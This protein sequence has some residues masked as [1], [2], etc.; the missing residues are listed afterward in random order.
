MIPFDFEYYK[1]ESVAEAV[2][3]FVE[4]DRQGKQPLYFSGG[5]EIISMARLNSVFTQAVVDIKGIFEC[6]VLEMRDNQLMIGAAVT[7]TRILESNLFPLLGKSGGRIADHTI[8]D[9][10]TLGGNLCG[11]II[12][13]EAVLP[14]LLADCRVV[15]AGITGQKTV[16]IHEVFEQTFHLSKGELLVQFIVDQDFTTL[17]HV[18]IKRTRLDKI[19]YPLVS[20]AAIKKDRWIRIALSGLCAFPFRSP[21]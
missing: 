15:I 6:N 13:R 4:L 18:G 19:D 2:G 20:L 14:L 21:M 7:M 10:I 5:T 1:P 9:K 16:L 8:R 17:P 11:K 12:Y 3:L